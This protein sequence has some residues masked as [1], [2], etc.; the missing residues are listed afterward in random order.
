M[1]MRLERREQQ[2]IGHPKSLGLI[3][4]NEKLLTGL[5][6]KYELINLCFRK[7]TENNM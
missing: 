4:G 6:E 5:S 7:I 2:V 3:L 1:H